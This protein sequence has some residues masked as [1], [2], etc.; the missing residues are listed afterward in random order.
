[1]VLPDSKKIRGLIVVF[2]GTLFTKSDAPSF[3]PNSKYLVPAGIFG[4]QNYALVF[5]DYPGFGRDS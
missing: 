1:M 3:Q 5:I 2:H 4:S